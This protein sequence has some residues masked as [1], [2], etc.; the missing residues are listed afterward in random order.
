MVNHNNWDMKMKNLKNLYVAYFQKKLNIFT[1]KNLFDVIDMN[2]YDKKIITKFIKKYKNKKEKHLN[3]TAL[4]VSLQKGRKD[5]ANELIDNKCELN[6]W[7]NIANTA[8]IYAIIYNHEDIA[9]RLINLNCDI[10]IKYHNYK[11]ILLYVIEEHINKNIAFAL[12]N[13]ADSNFEQPDNIN[14]FQKIFHKKKNK[15]HL[16]DIKDIFGDTALMKIITSMFQYNMLHSKNLNSEI[17]QQLYSLGRFPYNN[18]HSTNLHSEIYQHNI[19]N[20]KEIAKKLIDS[21][22]NLNIRNKESYTALRLAIDFQ[23]ADIVD[24]IIDKYILKNGDMLTISI[25]AFNITPFGIIRPIYD[26]IQKKIAKVC[27]NKILQIIKQNDNVMAI[28]FNNNNL[29]DLNVISL[30]CLYL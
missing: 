28:C 11:T 25:S 5:I 23:L 20:Y 22:C 29:G 27:E 4:M 24:L 9:I 15:V 2:I 1:P 7:D 30:I 12:I 26:N 10:N 8:L 18:L 3:Q 13:K 21:S 19:T 16:A 6:C 17:Y 14:L